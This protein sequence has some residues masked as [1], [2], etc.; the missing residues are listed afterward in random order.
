MAP[1]VEKIQ[2]IPNIQL[3]EG[4]HWD[5]A[6]QSLYFV[7]IFGKAIHKYVPA[8][9]KH[10]KAVFDKPVSLIVPVKGQRNKFVIS[11]EREV[12]VVTWDGESEKASSLSKLGEVDQG[13]Q[14]RINDGKCDPKGRLWFGTMGAEPVYG[15]VE[16]NSGSFFS[17]SNSKI[18][19]HLTKVGISNGSIDQFDIKLETGE[20]SNR[21]AIFTLNKHNIDGVPDGMTIDADGN[22]WVAIF[23][24]YKVLKINPRKP[25][26]LIQTV[27]IPAKQTTSVAWGGPNLDILYVTSASFTVDGVKGLPAD[28]FVL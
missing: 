11:L 17:Y 6:T 8:T 22:L 14:T 7:D 4:P 19:T 13:T 10:T 21:Q 2:E 28:E 24:G 3:G 25:E 23:N 1:V 18:T 5:I 9:G 27:D 12:Y 16:P 15:Q 26:T 20:I